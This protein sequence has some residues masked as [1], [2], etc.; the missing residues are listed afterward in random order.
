[1]TADIGTMNDLAAHSLDLVSRELNSTLEASR[2]ELE[3][4]MEGQAGR[5]ALVRA[6]DL[7]HLAHG[8]LKVIEVH[9]AG[10]LADEM[11]Q[12]CRHLATLRDQ[13][14]LE[15]GLE[16]LT[17][18]TVQLPAYLDRV[19]SGGRDVALV[20][21]P[22]LNDLRQVRGI[23][24]LS[25]GSL[26]LLNAGPYER[27]IA[28]RPQVAVDSRSSR[29]FQLAARKLRPAFQTALLHWI[30]G[31][32]GVQQLDK[33]LQVSDALAKAASTEPVQ[34]LW[35]VLSAVLIGLKSD[36]LEATVALKRLVGQ[37][38]RQLKRLIDG[39]E[40]A[41]IH[42]PPVDLL[43]S[44]LYY[45]A[46]A[47]GEHERLV[48]IRERYGLDEA[49]PAEEQ[50][51]EAREGLSGPSVKLM[52]TVA[53]AIKEDLGSVKDVLDIFVRTGMEDLEQLK[54]Q[55]DMLKKIG[56]T[57]GVL[58]LDR[59][60]DQIQREGRELAAIVTS[61]QITDQRALERM[62]ATL[63]DVEDALDRELVRAVVP[64]DGD[65]TPEE[66]ESAAQYRHVTQAVM[67]ECI[68]NLAKVKEAVTQLID[69][70]ADGRALEQVAPL[71]RGITAGLLMLNKTK[72]VKIVERIGN[73][74][75]SRLGPGHKPL[76]P[77]HMERLADAV[78]SVEYYMETV[79]TGR[80]DPWYML[81]NAGR[82]LELL[83][84]LPPTKGGGDASQTVTAMRP[85]KAA[86]EP[87]SVMEVDE[88]RSDPELL[89]LFI[90]EAKEEIA[91][92]DRFLPAWIERPDDSEALI[93]VR[94]SF[95]TLKGSGRMVGAQLIGEF[96]WSVESLLNR[97]INQTLSPTPAM[98]AFIGEAAGA[99]PQ[100]VE[101]L[102]IGTAPRV[103]VQLLMKRAEAFAAGDPD[104][105]SLTSESLRLPAV[106]PPAAQPEEPPGSGLDPVLSEIFVKETLGHLEVIREHAA[107]A[108]MGAVP[109]P[110]EEPLYRASHTLLGSAKMAGYAPAVALARPLAQYLGRHHQSGRGLGAEGVAALTAAADEIERLTAA[111]TAGE[112][113]APAA[114]LVATLERLDAAS[115]RDTAASERSLPD[116]SDAASAAE[117]GAEPA[118]ADADGGE[119]QAGVA[120][121]AAGTAEPAIAEASPPAAAAEPP[122]HGAPTADGADAG[123]VA[124]FDPEI[125]AIFT[126]EAA[127]ILE[128]ADTALERMRADGASPES[129]VEMQRLL[130]TLKGGA[131][132]A[133]I[134]PM[135]NLS[136]ALETLLAG[137]A[138]RRIDPTTQA[139]GVVQQ[140]I[141]RLHQ[142][143]DLVDAGRGLA[144]EAALIRRVEECARARGHVESADAAAPAEAA[145]GTAVTPSAAAPVEVS[146]EAPAPAPG[147]TEG[148]IE[149][150]LEEAASAASLD[151]RVEPGEEPTLSQPALTASADPAESSET[152]AHHAGREAA[153]ET[154]PTLLA[155]DA[156]SALEAASEA[157]AE[158]VPELAVGAGPQSAA[159]TVPELAAGAAAEPAADVAAGFAAEA[160]T[161]R[162]PAAGPAP[163]VPAVDAGPGAP[164]A[165]ELRAAE[166]AET[167][168]VDAALLD[169]L[170]NN[171]GEVSIFQ[172]RL[173]QQ[174]HSIDFHL[175]ELA[176]TV[177]RLREQLRK[178]EAETEAQ[179]LHRHQDDP[180]ADEGFDPLE[181]DRYSTIQQLSRALAETANDVASINELLQGLTTEADTL[182]TQ[183]ARVT[184]ELQDGLMQTRMVPFQRHAS[185][186]ARIVRQAAAE[187]GK[188]AELVVEGGGSEI[189]RQ[190]LE[191]MLPPFEHLLRNAVVH[192]LEKPDDRQRAGKSETGR[193]E[194]KLRREG[195][196]VLI[197]VG[198][199][200]G[201]LDLD[202]IRRK[203]VDQGL[204]DE[205]QQVSD[206]EAAELILRPGFS[207]APELTQSAGRGVGMDV[208]DN[209]VKKLGGSMRIESARGRGTR[210]LIRLPY[211][212]AVTHALIV[213]VGEETF[214]LPLP[215]I[216]G[217]TR[218]P[219]ETLHELLTQDE[220]RLDNG[221]V[222][223]RIQHLGSLVGGMPSALPEEETAVSLVLVR[224]GENSA[225]LLTDSLEGS[226][227]IVV[228]T[229][230]PH[231]GSVPGVS[232][233]TILG[234][235]RI[236]VILDAG[237]LLRGHRGSAVQ[238]PVAEQVERQLTALVVDDSITMRRVTQRLLERRGVRV[239]TAR[240]GLDA[241]TVLQDNE[242]DVILLDIEMPRMDGYQFASHVRNDAKLK[243]VPIIM[244]TSRSG[245]KHR[246][247]AIELGVN[248]Y[249]SKPYQEAQLVGSIEAL[250]GRSL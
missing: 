42:S 171:A 26:L 208:V 150:V 201:G 93:A 159:E 230:G 175:G 48:A 91:G 12:A 95:H 179:I 132:M 90:E 157:A 239:L 50:L 53:K 244:I 13:E 96:C 35:Q 117:D 204:V 62:A 151:A 162:R 140:C 16:A 197:E 167:A 29:Q 248:D 245:E 47:S 188:S 247:K 211:T 153:D 249:L 112:A 198:D 173:N 6:A 22:L 174:V 246:A 142:M 52:R 28:S 181:L 193:V 113:F 169:S 172:S 97:L 98:A 224:A 45:V 228:K 210:F 102:E 86:K 39:G 43:N 147:E 56:D 4:Y 145:G 109:L 192:G 80:N 139:L 137:M 191:N 203:A 40:A 7:L 92:I 128:G 65:A 36:D 19:L 250:L 38:D 124:A 214:A 105:A 85:R 68:V 229:L 116:V 18:A 222:S 88:E 66:A 87:P 186:L 130:H 5:D 196:E 146:D 24:T 231:L 221:G 227:E 31:D 81:D 238:P 54:P 69:A 84:T 160:A 212:L 200:G 126:E 209:E 33:L 110:V 225:A 133:G 111:L 107:A 190:V 125:A 207:T 74:I 72:A 234:D 170:L 237:T 77:E 14:Q 78:V 70:P 100:L 235:G 106:E 21:L 25:E 226:R 120:D 44:L 236:V 34:Q 143:R 163:A 123:V 61:G 129:L 101:Q 41:W 134:T 115:R 241:I 23:D 215:T 165:A 178:L 127:E 189:D 176:Q 121:G 64:G 67:G 46:R 17:R 118:A 11:E 9:G 149:I 217:I 138:D 37:A 194:L 55:L 220:P 8:A 71:L 94:R 183:Q 30:K 242:L 156:K 131:R 89:E 232:G 1:M 168:R 141:D 76:K 3:D 49:V 59:A 152:T 51:A 219:R 218:V 32:D 83:E 79:S 60:R 180:G 164:P 233:A 243:N 213:N 195:S 166:R 205:P 119:P 206:A 2:R 135:G 27:H 58:G 136:H 223:Y 216:E 161:P 73:V 148:G 154:E 182:L 103:D 240:D 10:M 104:A 144:E 57:L 122:E 185:R 108:R 75:G 82:C 155:E 20:L 187:T 114:D 199:D 202:A 99:L 15:S 184:G 63:L 177:T 158:T